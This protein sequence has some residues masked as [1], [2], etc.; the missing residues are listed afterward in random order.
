MKNIV[1]VKRSVQCSDKDT[2]RVGIIG[3]GYWGPNLIRNFHEVP[4]AGVAAICDL[5]VERLRPFLKKIP[6]VKITADYKELLKDPAIDAIVVATP[7]SMHFPIA[8]E[9]LRAGKHVLVEKPLTG[10]A[11]EGG[12]LVRL[13]HLRKKVLMVGH[14]F[15]YHPAV[16]KIGDLLQVGEL[17]EVQYIDSIRVNLGLYQM[18]NRN[19]IW[20]LAPHDIAIILNWLGAVPERVSAWGQSFVKKGV[21]DVAFLR[22]QFPG[23]IL[24][25]LHVSWL[26]PAKIRRMTV[27][28]NKKMIIYDDL[29]NVEKIKIA[30]Q[31]AHLNPDNPNLRVAYRIGDIVSP[32]IQVTEP[33]FHECSHFVES[34]RRGKRPKTDGENGL[35]VVRV[36]EAANRSIKNN[37]KWVTV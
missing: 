6:G 16:M 7:I 25:H 36:L 31:G 1:E 35:R 32:R 24:A 5:K 28:G 10:T 34:I 2:I 23:G 19:V 15:E 37:S 17:G 29:E 22:L 27:V 9:A 30:D 14:T 20:D 8:S 21:E 3:C 33:L 4:E 18:D 11:K 26:A 12:R 13:A